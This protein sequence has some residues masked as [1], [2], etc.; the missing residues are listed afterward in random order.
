MKYYEIITLKDGRQCCL[1]NGTEAD[2]EAA[3]ACFVLTHEQTDYLLTYL[4]ESPE[5]DSSQEAKFLKDKTESTNEIEILAEV[6][7]KVVGMAGIDCMGS[8]EKVRHR[9]D[10]GVSID[11]AY[12]GLGIG[13]A[14]TRACIACAKKAGYDQ[15]E[16]TVVAENKHAIALYLSEGF[17]EYGRNPR[18]FKSRFSGWQETV[19][20]RMELEP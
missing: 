8:Q 11:Q 6:G 14:L 13:R 5:M 15:I 4:K 19:L 20:M 12:W 2:G 1:R 7:G 17:I 18:G 9:A 16:L 10:F 3:L